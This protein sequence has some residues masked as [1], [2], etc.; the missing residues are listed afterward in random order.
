M[1]LRLINFKC[2][3]AR[4]ISSPCTPPIVP[5]LGGSG[6]KTYPFKPDSNGKSH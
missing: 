6:E 1:R 3:F 5:L 4:N 2:K